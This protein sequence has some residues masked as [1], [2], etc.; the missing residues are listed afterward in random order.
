MDADQSTSLKVSITQDAEWQ[1]GSWHKKQMPTHTP[2][3]AAGE[4]QLCLLGFHQSLSGEKMCLC[5]LTAPRDLFVNVTV[6]KS[7]PT[8]GASFSLEQRKNS[9][10]KWQNNLLIFYFEVIFLVNCRQKIYIYKIGFSSAV[11]LVKYDFN[12]THTHNL[13]TCTWCTC[14][15]RCTQM[16][17]EPVCYTSADRQYSVTSQPRLGLSLIKNVCLDDTVLS[18]TNCDRISCPANL[19]G[20]RVGW[21]VG[22]GWGG[23]KSVS[24]SC[25]LLSLLYCRY[26]VKIFSN[27]VPEN[28][29]KIQNL[30]I[31]LFIQPKWQI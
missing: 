17:Q 8:V 20:R 30:K 28:K 12:H 5:F 11:F 23:W 29:I 3:H 13:C 2:R 26:Q 16:S 14:T 10:C 21:G 15:H 6:V 1:D 19:G 24:F 25:F 9:R 31:S 18:L 27:Y 7:S 22:G 4:D